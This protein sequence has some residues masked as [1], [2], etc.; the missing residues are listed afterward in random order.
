[1]RLVIDTNITIGALIRDSLLR[2]II[3]SDIF[4]LYAPEYMFEEVLKHKNTILKKSGMNEDSF[5]A[6]IMLLEKHISFVPKSEYIKN[7]GFAEEVMKEIDINDSIF[8]A[9]SLTINCPVWSDDGHFDS[10]DEVVVY[11]TEDIVKL[12]KL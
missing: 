10:Q 2:K 6:L 1:M 9:A 4:E 8:I 5:T 7:L 3:L 11:K 12:I